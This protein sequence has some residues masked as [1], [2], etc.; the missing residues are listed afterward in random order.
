MISLEIVVLEGWQVGR[1]LVDHFIKRTHDLKTRLYRSH[2]GQRAFC[3]I[4]RVRDVVNPYKQYLRRAP[5]KITLRSDSCDFWFL[6][7][8]KS[9]ALAAFPAENA[10]RYDETESQISCTCMTVN[11][12]RNLRHED[13]PKHQ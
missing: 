7:R 4:S 1:N 8:L 10:G 6:V 13:F 2:D 9:N 5:M 12:L 11:F 3:E